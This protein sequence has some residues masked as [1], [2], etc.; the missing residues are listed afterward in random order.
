VSRRTTR[1]CDLNHK[2]AVLNRN[3]ASAEKGAVVP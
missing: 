3:V 1:L 2:M